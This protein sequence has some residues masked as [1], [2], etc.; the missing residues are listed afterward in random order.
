MVMNLQLILIMRAALEEVMVKIPANDSIFGL[1]AAM[2]EVILKAAANGQTSFDG[3]VA[4][5][6]EQIQTVTSMLT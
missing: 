6:S 1:K 3:L 2:A 4:S 5:A